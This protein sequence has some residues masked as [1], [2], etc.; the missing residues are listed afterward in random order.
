MRA[1]P[2]DRDHAGEDDE[3]DDRGQDRA[4][5]GRRARRLIGL[6][7][8]VAETRVRQPLAGIGLH[9]PDRADQL[10]RIGGGIGERILRAARQPPHPASERD[11]RHHDQRNREQHEA[12]ELRARH[13]HHRGGAEEQH[14]VAQRDRDGGADRGLDL[15]GVGGEPRDQLARARGIEEGRR[16]REQMREHV[17]AQIGDDALADGHDEVVARGAGER[18]HGDDRDHHAEIAVDHRDAVRRQAEI[19]HPPHRDRHQQR[20]QRGNRQRDQREHGA[21]AVARDIGPEREQRPQLGAPLR[22]R[23]HGL[24]GGCRCDQRVRPRRAA[25]LVV[26]P[27]HCA[28]ETR[29]SVAHLQIGAAAGAGK[30][31]KIRKAGGLFWRGGIRYRPAQIRHRS[32]TESRRAPPQDMP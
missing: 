10:G 21:A 24:A 26:K 11:Q 15:G 27:F 23:D 6:L 30:S 8:L 12:G 28:H 16:Q 17:A 20:G 19:D 25:A 2:E 1:D 14:Q 18:E 7:D 9:G 29:Q 22:R 3:D 4:R 32:I 5:L 31:G 13:H